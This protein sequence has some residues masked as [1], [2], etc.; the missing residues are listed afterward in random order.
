MT[1]SAGLWRVVLAVLALTAWMVISSYLII[2]NKCA[3]WRA[4]G[5]FCWG[6]SRS[7]PSRPLRAR[8]LC[9]GP[10]PSIVRQ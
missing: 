2:L 9:S 7:S 1:Y 3:R 4:L 10:A 6:S 8:M 5:R